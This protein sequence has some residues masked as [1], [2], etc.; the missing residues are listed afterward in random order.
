M[1]QQFHLVKVNGQWRITN[2]LPQ[3]RMLTQPDFASVYKPQDLYFFDPTG[4]VLVP[5]SVFVPVGTS[6]TFLVTNLVGALQNDPQSQWLKTQTNPV[7]PAI[8]EFPPGASINVAVVGTTATVNLGGRR[9]RPP[10]PTPRADRRAAGLD[11]DRAAGKPA[12]PG[13][14]P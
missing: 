8:T 14:R 10:I 4:Q 2:P 12:D 1:N 5:D 11:P 9:R 7:P 13:G 6:P 3:G